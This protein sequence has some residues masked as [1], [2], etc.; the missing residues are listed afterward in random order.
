MELGTEL[1]GNALVSSVAVVAV[2]SL[3]SWVFELE[4][5][6]ARYGFRV[7]QRPTTTKTKCG[8]VLPDKGVSF[9]C[10]IA[11]VGS[12]NECLVLSTALIC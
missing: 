4:H 9:E 11:S 8:R 6:G 3:S 10:G 5:F 7:K 12:G 2:I 1:S